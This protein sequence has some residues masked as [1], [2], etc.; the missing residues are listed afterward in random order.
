M[1]C[2]SAYFHDLGEGGGG[3]AA[4]KMVMWPVIEEENVKVL[5]AFS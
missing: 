3:E 2:A 1:N 4:D 5:Q